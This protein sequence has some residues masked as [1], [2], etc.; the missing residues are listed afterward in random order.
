MPLRPQLLGLVTLLSHPYPSCTLWCPI[1]FSSSL[2]WVAYLAMLICSGRTGISIDCSKV[3]RFSRAK[4]LTTHLPIHWKINCLLTI[5]M[6]L[7]WLPSTSNEV[8]IT[9]S[10]ATHIFDESAMLVR[11]NHSAISHQ[12]SSRK[13]FS[14]CPMFTNM[15]MTLT[16]S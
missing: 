14:F 2:F 5:T 3:W 16:S 15:S 1:R 4:S 12:T 7:T 10:L 11:L 9:A 8:G 13:K 6:A